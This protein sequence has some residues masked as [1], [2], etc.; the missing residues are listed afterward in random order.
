M[1]KDGVFCLVFFWTVL[2]LVATP[3]ECVED[4]EY[5]ERDVWQWCVVC[6]YVCV[7]VYVV[8][9]VCVWCVYVHVFVYRGG[10]R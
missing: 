2:C 7:H 6:V 8:C 3:V 4:Q 10:V 9:A 1:K 5:S